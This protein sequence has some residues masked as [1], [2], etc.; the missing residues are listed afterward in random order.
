MRG[1]SIRF[2]MSANHWVKYIKTQWQLLLI[3]SFFISGL[4]SGTL[5]AVGYIQSGDEALGI[6]VSG[7]VSSR[8]GQA[9]GE[10]FLSSIISSLPF[11]VAAFLCG[12]CAVGIPFIPIIAISRGIGLGIS[13]GY[14]Y[15]CYGIN[16]IL[17]CLL[18]I[19][20]GAVISSTAL[21]LACKQSLEYS[22]LLFCHVFM[23]HKRQ[24]KAIDIRIY[25][26]RYAVFAVMIILSAILDAGF[27]SLFSGFFVF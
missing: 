11:I 8:T 2:K 20:P 21:L 10:I 26:M 7:F 9:F 4:V 15:V 12:V 23:T 5:T 18:M 25:S 16:G 13:L 19:I 27:A 14:F 3:S 17:Y 22:Y 24:D 1:K 6:I